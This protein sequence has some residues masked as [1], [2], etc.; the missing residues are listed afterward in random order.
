MEKI[1][2]SIT[3]MEW[4]RYLSAAPNG[5]HKRNFGKGDGSPQNVSQQ[6]SEQTEDNSAHP[7][8]GRGG[9]EKMCHWSR[10]ELREGRSRQ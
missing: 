3:G 7:I 8:I 5:S 10:A 9:I 2:T 6:N 4:A 1:V